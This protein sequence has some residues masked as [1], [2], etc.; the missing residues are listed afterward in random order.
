MSLAARVPSSSGRQGE[1]PPFFATDAPVRWVLGTGAVGAAL[2]EGISGMSKSERAFLSCPAETGDGSLCS[3]GL[4][5]PP[6]AGID[7]VEYEAELHSMVQ[8]L[9]DCA[10]RV[11]HG[12]SWQG[13]GCRVSQTA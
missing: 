9:F 11:L 4:V 5:P 8:V 12:A 6:P 10:S 2:E 1:G 3:S 7:R 13:L